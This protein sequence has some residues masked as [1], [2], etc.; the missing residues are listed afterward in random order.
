[1]AFSKLQFKPGVNTEV[2]SY[3]NEGGWN[4]CD[5]V[6]FR[7][8]FPEKLG[9]WVK[10]SL[11]TFEGICRS[12]HAWVTSNGSKLMGVGTH[13]KFYVEEGTGFNDIAPLRN[14]TTGSATFAA[15]S[16]S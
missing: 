5:K 8:G 14:T 15:T 3:T 11:N 12:L 9:G 2:T 4:N 10:Y 13:L 7:F 6:R 16:G 1:M